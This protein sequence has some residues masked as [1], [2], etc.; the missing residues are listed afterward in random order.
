VFLAVPGH[1]G[2]SALGRRGLPAERVADAAADDL[3]AWMASGAAV[4]GH[5]ADQLVPVLALAGQAGA[6]SSFTCPALSPHLRTV[7]WVVEQ[8]LPVEV[9]L[10]EGSPARV[11]IAPV[12]RRPS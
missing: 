10:R 3:L 9:A 6:R 2:A 4:D 7:A 12:S 1:A 11:E 8:L 5:L